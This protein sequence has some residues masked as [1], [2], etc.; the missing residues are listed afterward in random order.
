M[1]RRAVVFL[2]AL[3]GV[4]GCLGR[5]VFHCHESKQCGPNGSCE[6]A[7]GAC[8]APD[9]TCVPSER[10]YLSDAPDGL[11]G[12]CVEDACPADPVMAIRAGGSH[13]CLLRRSGAVACWGAGA[14]G[15]LG[16]GTTEARSTVAPV[17]GLPAGA[18]GLALG[19]RHSCAIVAATGETAGTVWCWGAD[20]AGQLGDGGST[21]V[22]TPAPVPGLDSIA[23]LAA[24]AAFTCALRVPAGGAIAVLCWG[25]NDDGAIGA[26]MD[27]SAVSTP[28]AA[29]FPDGTVVQALAARGGHVCAVTN[30]GV[31]CWGSNSQGELG[32]GTFTARR[33]PTL[34]PGSAGASVVTAGLVHT[35]AVNDG[36]VT[37]WGANQVGE[38]GDGTTDVRLLP[39]VVT[40]LAGVTALASGAY[41]TC[42]VTG[43]G[44]LRCWGANQAGQLGEGT[45]SSVAVPV[46]VTGIQQAI[47]ITAGDNFSCARRNDGTVACWGD[48]RLGQ[49]GTAAPIRRR[50]PTPVA[51]LGNVQSLTASGDHTCARL[52]AG[53]NKTY[54][55]GHNQAGELGDGTRI[56]RPAPT[57]LKTTLDAGDLTAGQF[58]SCL[59]D[60][61]GGAW[62]WGRGSSGQLGTSS[63]IDALVPTAVLGLT[64]ATAIAAGA[65]HSCALQASAV[66]CWGAGDQ[67]QLGDGT[68]IDRASAAV[69][70][71]IDDATA[72]RLGDAHTCVLRATGQVACWGANDAGQL[73]N[74]TTSAS[75]D[76]VPVSFPL[77]T[78]VVALSAGSRHTC[79]VDDAGN[80][81]CWGA[82]AA[83]QLGW[84]DPPVDHGAPAKVMNVSD[85][86]AIAAGDAH[87]CALTSDAG[88][89]FCWGD[90]SSG[91]LGDDT[92]TSR[93]LATATPV[94]TDVTALAAG[95]AHTCALKSDRTVLCWGADDSGQLGEGTPLQVSVAQPTQISCP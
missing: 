62:C 92:L 35:C 9:P 53:S 50:V 89:V 94:M 49:L 55:W 71:G 7:T 11:A 61:A 2:F 33:V 32:D 41:H 72:I 73:G 90:N 3:A 59:V 79:A 78:N 26:G 82:G 60:A 27:V 88:S 86:V 5:G 39:V 65:A 75:A 34:V 4:T 16:D 54:C 43:D 68:M 70:P 76:P 80:A 44:T 95:H 12:Q 6:A 23:Q 18:V 85:V 51:A 69:V 20:E 22:L 74:A 58:H 19:D 17:S 42:A 52:P 37:C 64:G 81:Y 1:K 10:R 15:Q 47:E 91:Q 29:L 14:N 87:T 38:L 8:S 13:A 77:N 67:G 56:D 21:D 66:L 84:N 63:L 28:T 45:T 57:A 30:G 25:D 93:A 36:L 48:D 83:G 24:G 40:P 31:F 46:P